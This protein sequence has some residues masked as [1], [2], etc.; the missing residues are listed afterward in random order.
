MGGVLSPDIISYNSVI[1]ALG[2][3]GRAADALALLPVLRSAD[4]HATVTTMEALLSISFHAGLMH[5]VGGLWRDMV[6]AGM[7][8]GARSLNLFLTSLISLVRPP[9]PPPPFR[10]IT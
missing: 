8:P 5:E 1:D 7:R 3:A 10:S 2:A 6:R 9:R 4:L